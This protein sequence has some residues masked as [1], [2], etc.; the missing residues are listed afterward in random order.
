MVVIGVDPGTLHLGWG[1][2]RVEGTSLAHVDHGVVHTTAQASL[3]HRLGEID[4][5]LMSVIARYAPVEAAVEA[6]FYA[7]DAQAASKL[8]HARG[9]VLLRL[10]RGGVALFEYAPAR[11][12][13]VVAGRG[14]A[15]KRQVTLMVK[16]LLGLPKPADVD[17]SDAL[18]VAIAHA[19]ISRVDAALRAGRVSRASDR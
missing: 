12:K 8:G 14:Q 3:S 9:V 19:R 4:D 15:D 18:A 6:L 1:I 10:V 16:T 7:K 5:A 17:A 2:I 13:R 11:V